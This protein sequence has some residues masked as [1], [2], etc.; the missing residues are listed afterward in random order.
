[1]RDD[2]IVI[3]YI[4]AYYLCISGITNVFECFKIRRDKAGIGEGRY[5][6]RSVS[7]KVGKGEGRYRI[8]PVPEKDGIGTLPALNFKC[9]IIIKHLINA[10]NFTQSIQSQWRSVEC[11]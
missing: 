4:D 10:R 5:W 1:M 6:R 9:T 8:R 11:F 3:E 7:D 2:M